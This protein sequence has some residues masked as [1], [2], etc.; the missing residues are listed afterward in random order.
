MEFEQEVELPEASSL[1]EGLT[2]VLRKDLLTWRYPPDAILT[3]AEVARRFQVSKTPAR[4]ALRQLVQ[5]GYLQV[6]P[7]VGYRVTPISIA[8]VHEIFHLRALLEG[9]AAALAALNATESDIAKLRANKEAWVGY[10]FSHKNDPLNY[11]K[12]H[13]AFHLDIA[14]LS[15]NSRL[16]DMIAKL[17]K[18]SARI[19]LCDPLMSLKGLEEERAEAEAIFNALERH[20]SATARQKMRTHILESKER[21]LKQLVSKSRLRI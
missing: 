12:Y 18:E 1:S 4:E 3:E 9:E 14:V 10:L 16:A 2:E 7:R 13:D 8:D 20:D 21:I 15:G 11:L 17:L 6:V 19:R 5:E